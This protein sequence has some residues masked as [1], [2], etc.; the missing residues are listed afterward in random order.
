[1]SETSEE[2]RRRKRLRWISLGEAIAIAAL[3]IS[4][5]GLWREWH[6]DG[7][8]ETTT[9]VEKRPA[10]PLTLRGKSAEGGR[11]LEI[12]PVE[13]SHALESLTLT[14]AGATPIEVGSDGELD[15]SAVERIVKDRDKD[16]KGPHSVPARIEARYV[17]AGAD[18]K[19]AGNYRLSYRWEGG[20][21]FGGH[22]LRLAGLS[23]G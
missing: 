6:K 19:A 4:G 8:P 9:V 12:S 17:E 18:K 14:I 1:M 16:S 7:E 10:I 21:L 22:S 3:I 11:I 2:T 13:S 23:R 15:A 20:G 5:L